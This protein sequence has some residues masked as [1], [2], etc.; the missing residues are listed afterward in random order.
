VIA[1]GGGSV[2]DAAKLMTAAVYYEGDLWDMFPQGQAYRR[3]PELVLPIITVPTLAA[4]GSKMNSD[5][6]I[7]DEKTTIKSFV[8]GKCLY[9]KAAFVDPELTISVPKDQTAY[10]TSATSSRTSPKPT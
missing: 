4:T 10:G 6:I 9:P 8:G 5:T 7:T 3:F 2:M 1:L